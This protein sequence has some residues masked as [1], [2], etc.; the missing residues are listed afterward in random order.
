MTAAGRPI[1]DV[2]HRTLR[3]TRCNVDVGVLEAAHGARTPEEH[4][5]LDPDTYVCAGCHRPVN[6][7]GADHP[8]PAP[9]PYNEFPEGF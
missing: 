3:C 6:Q 4:R 2:T 5:F 9:V 1:A 8:R 7:K